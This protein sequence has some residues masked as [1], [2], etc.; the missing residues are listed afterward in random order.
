MRLLRKLRRVRTRRGGERLGGGVNRGGVCSWTGE[1]ITRR[2]LYV[3]LGSVG[4]WLALV[5]KRVLDLR[6]LLNHP[7]LEPFS[8]TKPRLSEPKPTTLL[9]INLKTLSMLIYQLGRTGERDEYQSFI[10]KFGGVKVNG[11]EDLVTPA[12]VQVKKGYVKATVAKVHSDKMELSRFSFIS[13]L[14]MSFSFCFF[15]QPIV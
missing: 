3:V 6:F 7:K 9:N 14:L 15:L 8:H 1:R 4:G 12:N 5:V 2:K 10:G 11:L 13:S